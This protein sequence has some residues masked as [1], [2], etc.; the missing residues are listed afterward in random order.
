MQRTFTTIILKHQNYKERDR[1]YTLF[2]REMGK[3]TVRGSGARKS[4]AKLAPHLEPLMA[5]HIVVA[6]NR[7]CGVI[8]FALC[9]ESFYHVRQE[10]F[11]CASARGVIDTVERLLR[12]NDPHRNMYDMLLLYL[13][14]MDV[15]VAHN[16]A[17]TVFSIVTQG[18]YFQLLAQLGWNV[19]INVCVRCSV[20]LAKSTQYTYLL[21]DGGFICADCLHGTIISQR[22]KIILSRDAAA[23]LHVFGTQYLSDSHLAHLAKLTV[24]QAVCDELTHFTTRRID[25]VI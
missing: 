15:L 18:L 10:R 23:T 5:S 25:W 14:T 2:T 19:Q 22:Q 3:M 6:K 11:A 4:G 7:G 13:R 16:V 8:T 24:P 17:S 21:G 1:L 20:R 9:E 12:D